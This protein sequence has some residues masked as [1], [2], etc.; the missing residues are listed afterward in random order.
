MDATGAYKNVLP[1]IQNGMKQTLIISLIILYGCSNTIKTGEQSISLR[2]YNLI[3][4]VQYIS[5]KRIPSVLI[6]EWNTVPDTISSTSIQNKFFDKDGFL[7]ELKYYDKD[8]VLLLTSEIIKSKTGKYQGSKDFD[9]NGNQTNQ[10][11]IISSTKDIL[12]TETYGHKSGDLLSKSK[13]EYENHLV[14]KQYS[15][16]VNQGHN[17][18]YFYKRNNKGNEI[19]ISMI[20]EIDD[21]KMEDISFVEYVSFDEFG[22]WTKRIDY[23]NEKGNECLVTI[24]R[25]KYYE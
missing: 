17:S 24:R 13:T 6:E 4:N 9:K 12:E 19:E 8:S 23:N 11:I 10:T 2:S 14:K 21:Q 1:V 20:V 16:F 18:V 7:T 15:E 3:G 22:N 5:D 25:I